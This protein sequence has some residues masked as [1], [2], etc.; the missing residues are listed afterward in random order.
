MPAADV[1]SITSPCPAFPTGAVVAT[2]AGS[3]AD[4]GRQVA[5]VISA[6]LA[7]TGL[8]K[9]LNRDAFTAPTVAEVSAPQF[10]GFRT[11]AAQ[12]L[13]TGTVTATAKTH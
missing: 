7:G 3:T 9:P 11:A 12:A 10:G 5:D 2:P 6:N 1:V 8:F 13:A 4:L